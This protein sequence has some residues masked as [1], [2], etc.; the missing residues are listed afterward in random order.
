MEDEWARFK[1]R[2]D[3]WSDEVGDFAL[4]TLRSVTDVV[5]RHE[6]PKQ[7]ADVITALM[8]DDAWYIA[9]KLLACESPIESQLLACVFTGLRRANPLSGWEAFDLE[10]QVDVSTDRGVFRVDFMATG[11]VWP[12]KVC[13]FA[14]ECDGHDFHEKTRAQAARDK[15]RDRALMAAGIPVLRFTGSEIWRTPYRCAAEVLEFAAK[16]LRTIEPAE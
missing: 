14:I 3:R 15:Q 8:P 6:N 13:K 5:F 10:P 1:T 2:D 11:G 16:S 4:E 7:R 9:E 12:D